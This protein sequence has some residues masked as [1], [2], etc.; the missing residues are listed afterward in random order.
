VAAELARGTDIIVCGHIHRAQEVP[1]PVE[2]MEGIL[3]TLGDWED[4]GCHLVEE[5]GCWR[6]RSEQGEG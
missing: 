2:G 5:D 3:Y 1:N 6:L 4:T